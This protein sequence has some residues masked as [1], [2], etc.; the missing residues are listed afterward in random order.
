MKPFAPLLA[1][2]VLIPPAS[3]AA[4]QQAPAEGGPRTA[5][6]TAISEPI[7]LDGVLD[8]PAWA[9]A[10]KI[11]ALVQRQPAQGRAPTER[12]DVTL[13]TDADRLYV[14]VVA[15]DAEPR[16]VIG[17]QMARDASLASDDRVE[18]L[19]D[20]FRDQRS[21]FY[22]ATNPS[23]ALVDGLVASG[24]LNSDWDAIW[25]VRTRRTEQGW[26]AEFTKPQS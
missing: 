12:T 15:Y 6:V 9:T 22:F 8:E 7:T 19:L 4:R 21:A 13:L 5:I 1:A 17:T 3:A 23:G 18:I 24:Q 16:R 25:D 26:I 20:T 14:G 11:G 2:I 10:P